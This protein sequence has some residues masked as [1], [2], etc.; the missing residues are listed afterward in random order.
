MLIILRHTHTY[1][2][3]HMHSHFHTQDNKVTGRKADV[4]QAAYLA[5]EIAHRMVIPGGEVSQNERSLLLGFH[6]FFFALG[7]YF[8]IANVLLKGGGGMLL[9]TQLCTIDDQCSLLL[10]FHKIFCWKAFFIV[11]MLSRGGKGWELALN[12]AL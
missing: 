11:N 9:N 10:R 8:S 6:R 3:S 7:A 4:I 2:H 1:I 12:C 5:S